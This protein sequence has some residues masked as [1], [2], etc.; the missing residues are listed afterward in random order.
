M[1]GQKLRENETTVCEVTVS[2]ELPLEMPWYG[3]LEVWRSFQSQ[4]YYINGTEWSSSIYSTSMWNGTTRALIRVSE[5]TLP[6][7][8]LLRSRL[9]SVKSVPYVWV[10]V[11]SSA[12][13]PVADHSTITNRMIHTTPV[14][15]Q[16]KP[17]N[18]PPP[19]WIDHRDTLRFVFTMGAA[20]VPEGIMFMSVTQDSG[21]LVDI[22]DHLGSA[23]PELCV[24]LAS[25]EVADFMMY[26]EGRCP[27]PIEVPSDEY[28]NIFAV[29]LL[30]LVDENCNKRCK[31]TNTSTT[32]TTTASTDDT[33]LLQTL[34]D[35]N[36]RRRGG[37][38]RFTP[39]HC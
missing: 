15:K 18:I 33:T 35:T 29:V 10:Y 6:S 11:R 21:I 30:D 20:N 38:I 39:S 7:R 4:P 32:T 22:I 24:V 17:N 25:G 19:A 23:I 27:L 37:R 9:Q 16:L 31:P 2:K 8:A 5:L 14:G 1:Y 12:F 28:S 36:S 34:A 26:G 13:R 3:Y